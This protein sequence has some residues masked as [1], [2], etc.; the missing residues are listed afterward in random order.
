MRITYLKLVNFAGI[1]AGMGIREFELD[2]KDQKNNIVLLKASN[3]SGKTVILSNLNPYR[4]SFDNRKS[5]IIKDE[6]DE[7]EDGLKEIHYDVN[8]KEVIIKHYYSRNKNKSYVSVDGKEMNENGNIKSA[9]SVIEDVL[10]VSKDYF[11]VGR[12]GDNVSNFINFK[13]AKRKDYINTFVPDIDPYLNAYAVSNGKFKEIKSNFDSLNS[14]LTKYAEASVLKNELDDLN[15]TISMIDKEID[16]LLVKEGEVNS[17]I[18]KANSDLSNMDFSSYANVDN[19]DYESITSYITSLVKQEEKKV[20]EANIEMEKIYTISPSMKNFDDDKL[21]EL[22]LTSKVEKDKL[23]SQLKSVQDNASDAKIKAT[24]V[25]N[26]IKDIDTKIEGISFVDIDKL[27]DKSNEVESDI[28]ELQSKEY[29]NLNKDYIKLFENSNVAMVRDYTLDLLNQ[30]Q[31]LF[32]SYND[33]MKSL[34]LDSKILQSVMNNL[35]DNINKTEYVIE[36]LNTDLQNISN[37]PD[38]AH[39]LENHNSQCGLGDSCPFQSIILKSKNNGLQWSDIESLQELIESY[40]NQLN[41]LINQYNELSP[42]VSNIITLENNIIN[43]YNTKIEPYGLLKDLDMNNLITD[44]QISI[45]Q[46]TLNQL[47][48]LIEYIEDQ[49]NLSKLKESYNSIIQE[50]ET[51]EKLQELVKSYEDQKKKLELE[52]K[53][54]WDNY[55]EYQSEWDTILSSINK[56]NGKTKLLDSVMSGRK[57]VNEA[58]KSL[59]DMNRLLSDSQSLIEKLKESKIKLNTIHND[60][61]NKRIN[62]QTFENKKTKIAEDLSIIK[63]TQK[64]LD[65]L[66]KVFKYFSIIKQ[67][68]DPK[69]GIPLIFSNMYLKSIAETANKLLDIAYN[70][71]FSIDFQL[72]QRDFF[73]HVYKDDGS[74]LDDILEASQGEQSLTNLS[75]SLALLNKVSTGY[76]VLYLDEV[77]GV[78]STENRAKFIEMLQKQIDELNIEQTFVI[79]HNNS[80]DSTNVDLILLNGSDVNVNDKDF[81]E[82]KNVLFDIDQYAKKLKESD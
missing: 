55:E 40:N 20:E 5:L 69:K 65:E 39:A 28:N 11:T 43:I 44:N 1:Y 51:S 4:E 81:M 74:Y 31:D 38:I 9:Y 66:D 73:V 77:D 68:T 71:G 52:Q 13:T 2:M 70:G 41:Q 72:T 14:E 30:Y 76:N 23:N 80:F 48:I 21:K 63:N 46:S 75:L 64:R 54:Y 17:D 67:A 62:K 33:D 45:I 60:T 18:N 26:S 47:S 10:S 32:E 3:G 35:K 59:D 7:I 12:L 82:G 19:N 8:G 78:L 49:D 58:N 24:D 34:G 25:E 61:A 37:N 53:S 29:P 56:E 57:V 27:I 42:Q 79:S 50:K 36:S 6:N 16:D 22:L 15:K